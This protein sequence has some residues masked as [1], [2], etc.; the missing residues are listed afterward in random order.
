MKEIICTHKNLKYLYRILQ[1][2]YQALCGGHSERH[3]HGGL[4]YSASLLSDF[5][6]ALE[7]QGKSLNRKRRHSQM[8]VR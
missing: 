2:L 5:L 8:T 7:S 3:C 6:K 1:K 4:S